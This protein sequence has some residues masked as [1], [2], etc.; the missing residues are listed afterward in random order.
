MG[1]EAY[2]IGVR[3]E[4]PQVPKETVVE[5]L[6]NLGATNTEKG[7]FGQ[8]D[9]EIEYKEGY[10]EMLLYNLG[11]YRTLIDEALYLKDEDKHLRSKDRPNRTILEM[12]FAKAN[13]VEMA[14]RIVELMR[15]LKD[16]HIVKEVGDLEKRETIDLDDYSEF[17]ERVKTAKE[18]FETWHRTVPYPIR[19][20]EYFEIY[21]KLYPD[22]YVTEESTKK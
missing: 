11:E 5:E 16:K 18:E 3:F 7:K 12:R 22:E 17:K 9:L 6:I 19:C 13:S 20:S 2:R 10:L 4:N 1:R 15:V 14:D 8:V 21:H